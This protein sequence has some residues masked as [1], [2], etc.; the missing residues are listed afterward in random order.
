MIIAH[1]LL[2]NSIGSNEYIL[3]TKSYLDRVNG[4]ISPSGLAWR[5]S[6]EEYPAV[7]R[8]E[9]QYALLEEIKNNIPDSPPREDLAIALGDASFELD[10][11][12]PIKKVF[13]LLTDL[14]NRVQWIPTLKRGEGDTPIERLGA[15]HLCI[16]DEM[17]VE[18]TPQ[19]CKINTNEIR[20][21]ESHHEASLGLEYFLDCRLTTKGEN[22]THGVI[23]IGTESGHELAPQ[24]AAMASE[25]TRERLERFKTFCEAGSS[26]NRPR[27][28]GGE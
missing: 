20:Y 18:V 16:F 15:R 4:N 27:G 10:I 28:C 26:S 23:R 12:A 2:K 22:L 8:L 24:V 17:T 9:F 21:V 6:S 5:S 11:A 14:D 1:R 19:T 7:G 3:A 25:N 13:E